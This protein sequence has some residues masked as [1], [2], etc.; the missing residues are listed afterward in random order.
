MK[1]NH[2]TTIIAIL[3]SLLL[4]TACE[5]EEAETTEETPSAETSP[6]A[7]ESTE[8][9]PA[10]EEAA[11]P[12]AEQPAQA[13][14]EGGG[15]G[16]SVCGRA[17]TCCEAYVNAVAATTP[18]VTAET[19]CAGVRQAGNAPGGDATC[20]AAIAGW[21]QSL[22]ALNQTVPASCAE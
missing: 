20:T 15:A 12:A 16:D 6:A 18:G 1:L 4:V 3:A 22:T 14:G 11:E 8:E 13:E 2:L 7:E 21:R 10:A 19:A 9:Q 17:V 5:E